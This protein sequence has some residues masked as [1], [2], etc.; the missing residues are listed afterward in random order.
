MR[1]PVLFCVADDDRITP[2]APALAAAARTPVAELRRYP[3]GHFE[4]YVPPLFD[5]VVADETEFLVRH[6]GG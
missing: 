1:C 2:P 5:R 4:P 6:L 3:G